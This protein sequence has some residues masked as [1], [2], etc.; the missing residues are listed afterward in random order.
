MKLRVLGIDILL[1]QVSITDGRRV[2][3]HR[4]CISLFHGGHLEN[5]PK[6][7]VGPKISSDNILILNL[8]GPMNNIIPRTEGH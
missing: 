4:I 1:I 7:R 3:L 2:I 8:G 6:S 5:H